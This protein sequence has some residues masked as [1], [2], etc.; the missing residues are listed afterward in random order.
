M[1]I[2]TKYTYS[3]FIPYHKVYTTST[4][5]AKTYEKKLNLAQIKARQIFFL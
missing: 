1:F 4:S 3:L 2:F 5:R